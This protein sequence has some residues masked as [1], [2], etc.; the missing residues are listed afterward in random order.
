MGK[1]KRTSNY[2]YRYLGNVQVKGKQ[3][4]VRIYDLFDGD[5][6]QEIDI[7]NRTKSSFEN[8]IHS[9]FKKNFVK[10]MEYFAKAQEDGLK[11]TALDFYMKRM[12]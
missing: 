2:N 8:G 11:D 9:Y 5:D 7:K 3:K 1:I 4:S 10:A 12:T 6:K